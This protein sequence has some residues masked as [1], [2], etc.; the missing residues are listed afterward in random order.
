MSV[1]HVPEEPDSRT[2]ATGTAAAGTETDSAAMQTP[3]AEDRTGGGS[4][5]RDDAEAEPAT[6]ESS[7]AAAGGAAIR[8]QA[9]TLAAKMAAAFTA[10][11]RLPPAYLPQD[12][13]VVAPDGVR[14]SGAVRCDK[15]EGDGSGA[16]G[17]EDTSAPARHDTGR[18]SGS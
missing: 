18:C 3:M 15:G 16:G 11:K 13:V 7:G 4:G 5:G 1:G 12:A 9:E 2:A 6:G 14:P 8:R 17:Q 10:D